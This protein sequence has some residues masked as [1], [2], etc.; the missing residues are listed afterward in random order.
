MAQSIR[1][2]DEMYERGQAACTVASRSLAQQFEH[3]ARLGEALDRGGL[4]SEQAAAVL[5]GQSL[6]RRVAAQHERHA[7]EVTEG[8][9]DPANLMAI[10]P[11]LARS[12]RLVF[13]TQDKISGKGW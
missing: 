3:W 10:P 1:I 8:R 4:T 9:R 5:R 11:R 7:R 13:P 12:A 6:S 2:S